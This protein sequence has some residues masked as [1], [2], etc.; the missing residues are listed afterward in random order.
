MHPCRISSDNWE[1]SVFLGICALY[2]RAE[3]RNPAASHTV[4]HVDLATTAVNH[5]DNPGTHNLPIGTLH[6]SCLQLQHWNQP[7]A[8]PRYLL[9]SNSVAARSGFELT[10][11]LKHLTYTMHPSNV[12]QF[13]R[14]YSTTNSVYICVDSTAKQ[15][16]WL[17]PFIPCI[18]YVNERK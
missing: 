10:I 3:R 5:A 1:L 15:P 8:N 16:I 17:A 4:S 12:S 9:R 18:F 7:V 13:R 14:C 6:Y 2:T 11:N